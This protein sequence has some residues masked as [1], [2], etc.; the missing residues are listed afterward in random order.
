MYYWGL[1]KLGFSNQHPV[2]QLLEDIIAK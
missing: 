2:F 1:A